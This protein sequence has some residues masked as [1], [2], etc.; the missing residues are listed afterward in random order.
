LVIGRFSYAAV[1]L[2]A[3]MAAAGAGLLTLRLMM[4]SEQKF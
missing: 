4:T 2:L 3:A 1:Y